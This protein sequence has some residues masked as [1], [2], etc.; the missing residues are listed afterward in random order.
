MPCSR[1]I[2]RRTPWRPRLSWLL[3]ALAV[4]LALPAGAL[5]ATACS[6][7]LAQAGQASPPAAAATASTSSAPS[8]TPFVVLTDRSVKLHMLEGLKEPPRILIFGGSRATRIEPAS[9]RT[10]TG[11]CGFNLALQNGR[12]E[13]AWAC[14]NYLHQR[15]PRAPLQAVW[16]L[17]VEAFRQQTLSAGLVQEPALSRWFP[18]ELVAAEAAALQQSAAGLQRTGAGVPTGRDLA[19]TTFAP[20]G[21]VVRNRY[22]IREENGNTLAKGLQYSIDTARRRYADSSAALFPRSQRYF[23]QTIRLL[24]ALGTTQ[25][26]VLAPLHPQLLAAVKDAGWSERHEEILA[27]LR[28]VQ[29]RY[30]FDLLDA[31]YLS[32]IDGDPQEFYDGFHMKRTNAERLVQTI[33]GAFPDAFGLDGAG[34]R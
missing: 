30:P 13:D 32:I 27:Y 33:V 20:D 9:F 11:L 28:E 16:V 14:V 15:F 6:S 4:T 3:A 26:V 34:S 10:L 2:R 24:D 12:P 31:S 21:S 18:K 7:V 25:V 1:D 17:H 5:G 19:I 23:E 29:A 8:S 22:D